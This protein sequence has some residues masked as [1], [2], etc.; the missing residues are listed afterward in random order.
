MV[1]LGISEPST[2][3]YCLSGSPGPHDSTQ[4]FACG[5]NLQYCHAWGHGSS[6]MENDDL[7]IWMTCLLSGSP[8]KTFQTATNI[9]SKRLSPNLQHILQ[10][11]YIWAFCQKP[12]QHLLVAGLNPFEKYLPNGIISPGRDENKKYLSCHHQVLQEINFQE[13]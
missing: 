4:I 13:T 11:L 8:K 9:S 7:K 2:E 10:H 5:A 12:N 3:S 6:R 1:G